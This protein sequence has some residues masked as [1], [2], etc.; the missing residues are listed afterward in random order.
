MAASLHKRLTSDFHT[1]TLL[2][3]KTCE[4]QA[5]TTTTTKRGTTKE[6]TKQKR[7]AKGQ[8]KMCELAYFGRGNVVAVLIVVVLVVVLCAT[9]AQ[10]DFNLPFKSCLGQ[11]ISWASGDEGPELLPSHRV[12]P[13]STVATGT[14]PNPL[15]VLRKTLES[16]SCPSWLHDLVARSWA[17]LPV[18]QL[19]LQRRYQTRVHYLFVYCNFTIYHL[20]GHP[21]THEQTHTQ[22]H[23]RRTD[24]SNTCRTSELLRKFQMET[25]R[26]KTNLFIPLQ[27]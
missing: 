15:S 10:Q 25:N 14:L 4:Q 27:Q 26:G 9:A 13:C 21:R 18:A 23:T 7:P 5:E 16:A 22:A 20:A 17:A 1:Y 24:S 6:K 3:R 11:G 8:S 19:P 12:Q 2:H